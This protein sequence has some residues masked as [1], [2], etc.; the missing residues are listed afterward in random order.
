MFDFKWVVL[1]GQRPSSSSCKDMLRKVRIRTI[2]P[3]TMAL[4]KVGSTTTVRMM[5]PEFPRHIDTKTKTKAPYAEPWTSE[6]SMGS[7]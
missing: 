6:L 1:P 4:S 2:R 7:R 3:R 5:S